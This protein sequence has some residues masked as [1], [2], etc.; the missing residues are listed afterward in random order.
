MRKFFL[1]PTL[2]CLAVCECTVYSFEQKFRDTP[3]TRLVSERQPDAV[4]AFVFVANKDMEGSTK[5]LGVIVKATLLGGSLGLWPIPLDFRWARTPAISEELNDRVDGTFDR[6]FSD[7]LNQELHA[8]TIVP[9]DKAT[10]KSLLSAA[11]ESGKKYVYVVVYNQYKTIDFELS[12]KAPE[13]SEAQP[14]QSRKT[15]ISIERSR[16]VHVTQERNA[17]VTQ[18]YK[19]SP[20]TLF[21][22]GHVTGYIPMMSRLM[23]ATDDGTVLINKQRLSE[24]Y[25]MMLL[26]NGWDQGFTYAGPQYEAIKKYLAK[27]AA[28]NKDKAIEKSIQYLIDIDFLGG[29]GSY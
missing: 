11:R 3:M 1:A 6:E 22:Y 25:F 24:T 7:R 9:K 26:C 4:V 29:D 13:E 15:T 18:T 12:R 8:E 16:K 21:N 28:P 2:L 27:V 5:S 10:V 14:G 19:P 20:I 23:I 17:P